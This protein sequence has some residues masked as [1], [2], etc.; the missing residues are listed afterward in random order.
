MSF[1]MIVCLVAY[2]AYIVRNHKITVFFVLHYQ[3]GVLN[4]NVCVSLGISMKKIIQFARNVTFL[5]NYA[6]KK[7]SNVQNVKMDT[8]WIFSIKFLRRQISIAN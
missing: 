7:V 8:R 5:V 3:I 4:L 2:N 6:N 1:R